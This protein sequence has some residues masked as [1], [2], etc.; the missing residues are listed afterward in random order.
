M[1]LEQE[2]ERLRKEVARLNDLLSGWASCVDE[3]ER[4]V[5]P[6]VRDRVL[7]IAT[8]FAERCGA[9]D[10]L[11]ILW[12][13]G[14]GSEVP[15]LTC[16]SCS[17]HG[18]R[19]AGRIAAAIRFALGSWSSVIIPEAVE[20][21]RFNLR[22][23]ASRL[24]IPRVSAYAAGYARARGDSTVRWTVNV[25][26]DTTSR[27]PIRTIDGGPNFETALAEARR[28]ADIVVAEQDAVTTIPD[29]DK[30]SG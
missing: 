28:Q 26:A 30:R 17:G 4:A 11:G 2:N 6:P 3:E 5:Q 16:E 24:G 1:N 27:L 12:P 15:P 10:G 8:W 13:K 19:N 20:V 7:E 22:N 9:C 21:R 29:H 14:V 23:P 18:R 25:E